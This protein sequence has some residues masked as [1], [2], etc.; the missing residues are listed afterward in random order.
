MQNEDHKNRP[1]LQGTSR[2]EEIEQIWQDRK[3]LY[4]EAADLI[5]DVSTQSEDPKT[6]VT[7]KAQE[8]IKMLHSSTPEC[9]SG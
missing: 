7:Q 4:R 8:I 6:D 2:E 5:Y 9:F 1:L 3:E